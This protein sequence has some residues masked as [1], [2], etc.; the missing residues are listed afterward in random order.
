MDFARVRIV[1]AGSSPHAPGEP[2]EPARHPRRVGAR[3]RGDRRL[4]RRRGC[5]AAAAG[6][7]A[8]LEFGGW[9]VTADE[10]DGPLLELDEIVVRYPSR[11]GGGEVTALAATTLSLAD[12]A[13][14]C[15]A[16]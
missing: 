3:G 12:G 14:V 1:G 10:R 6:S 11:G 7:S 16:G 5:P 4:G 13:F 2:P 9:D 15:V 8:K